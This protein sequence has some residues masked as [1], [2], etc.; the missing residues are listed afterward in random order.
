MEEFEGADEGVGG[1]VGEASF[2]AGEGEELRKEAF[3]VVGLGDSFGQ[4]D[5]SVVPDALDI[6]CEFVGVVPAVGNR[7]E[8]CIMDAA[9]IADIICPCG[10]LGD[11]PIETDCAGA[12][13]THFQDSV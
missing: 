5:A 2:F 8:W 6:F 12:V 4:K 1:V 13:G 7:R 9:P 3:A 11:V 10:F